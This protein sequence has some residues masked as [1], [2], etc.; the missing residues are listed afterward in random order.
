[1]R[2]QPVKEDAITQSFFDTS[3]NCMIGDGQTTFFW[4][5]PWLGGQCIDVLMPELLD[6]VPTRTRRRR[7]VTSALVGHAWIRDITDSLMIPVLI[8]YLHLRQQLNIVALSLGV[9]DRIIW[10]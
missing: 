5:D 8:Q 4:P 10:K 3:I 1:L 6:V 2:L 7:T 9:E